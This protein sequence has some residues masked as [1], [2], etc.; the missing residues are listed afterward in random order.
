VRA[1]IV[2]KHQIE[3]TLAAH[4]LSGDVRA[5]RSMERYLKFVSTWGATEPPV[6]VICRRYA[7]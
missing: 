3:R 5:S 4:A 7:S 1:H 2:L 6:T